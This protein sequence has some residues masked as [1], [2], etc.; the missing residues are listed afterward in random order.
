[1]KTFLLNIL[2]RIFPPEQ[3]SQ[4]ELLSYLREQM[5]QERQHVYLLEHL[6]P[7]HGI[8]LQEVRPGEWKCPTPHRIPAVT[9]QEAQQRPN[10]YQLHIDY[11]QQKRAAQDVIRHHEEKMLVQKITLTKDDVP[12]DTLPPIPPQLTHAIQQANAPVSV[13]HIV[14]EDQ[15]L[16]N[17]TP[18]EVPVVDE[19]TTVSVPAIM[20]L[21][22]VS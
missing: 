22:H 15:W 13:E 16:L 6:C 9:Q 7:E 14:I 8:A 17:N 10:P 1:M 20:K 2:N 3:P 18:I 11:M 21:K 4:S 12:T 19:D 5:R